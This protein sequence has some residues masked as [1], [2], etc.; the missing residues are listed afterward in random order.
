MTKFRELPEER[1]SIGTQQ[2]KD[3]SIKLVVLSAEEEG[4]AANYWS[5]K[6]DAAVDTIQIEKVIGKIR[7]LL[8]M[9]P[10]EWE[11]VRDMV[12]IAES[13]ID[14][15]KRTYEITETDEA[16]YVKTKNTQPQ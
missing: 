15:S 2:R 5:I 6:S 8:F 11:L 12:E 7:Y 13:M 16:I 14:R 10:D 1:V 4:S 9:G 3:G